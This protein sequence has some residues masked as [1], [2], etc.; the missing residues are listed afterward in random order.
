MSIPHTRL[1]CK[2]KYIINFDCFHRKQAQHR[3][4]AI[5]N[6]SISGAGF[7]F[8]L[9]KIL[10]ALNII[11]ADNGPTTDV[12]VCVVGAK[13]V[14]KEVTSILRALWSASIQCA[15]VECNTAEDGQDMAKDMGAVYYVIYCDDGTL[16]LRSWI[17]DR[18]EERLFNREELITYIKRALRPDA[19]PSQNNSATSSYSNN[20]SA[21]SSFGRSN[22]S[23]VVSG[24]IQQNVIVTFNCFEKLTSSSRR[25]YENLMQQ[26]MSISLE[27][28]NKREKVNVIIVDLPSQVLR[29]VAGALDPRGDTSKD[30]E[31][32]IGAV[33]QTHADYRRYIRDIC[34]E[35]VDIYL[36]EKLRPVVG[37]YSLKDSSYRFIL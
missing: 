21:S 1:L 28:F 9:D 34:E 4:V 11:S 23:T 30:I 17:N 22:R 7:S 20:D 2:K 35:I 19:D 37:L 36:E 6:R 31:G 27:L 13:P 32:D 29:A 18:F 12:V 24:P 25:R 16:H 5:P 26:H 3:G 33:A 14:L 8:A 15:V 10:S